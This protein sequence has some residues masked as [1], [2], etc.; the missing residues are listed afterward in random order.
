MRLLG[1]GFKV[2]GNVDI[3]IWGFGDIKVFYVGVLSLS[4]TRTFALRSLPPN[5]SAKKDL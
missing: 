1:I 3:W 5:F 4:L 2:G